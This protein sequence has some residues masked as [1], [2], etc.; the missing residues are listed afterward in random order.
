VAEIFILWNFCR[1]WGISCTFPLKFVLLCCVF[2]VMPRHQLRPVTTGFSSSA[3][4]LL[5]PLLSLSLSFPYGNRNLTG[6]LGF[7]SSQSQQL[8]SVRCCCFSKFCFAGGGG[9]AT[10]G[11]S[12]KSLPRVF[13][14]YFVEGNIIFVLQYCEVILWRSLWT[15]LIVR[16]MPGSVSIRVRTFCL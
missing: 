12:A 3:A 8:N 11:E 4:N 9:E 16:I 14:C 10:C 2:W 6:W 1:G 13:F 15:C 5:P 7:F